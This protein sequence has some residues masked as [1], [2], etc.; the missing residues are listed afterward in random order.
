MPGPPI[1]QGEANLLSALVVRQ[2]LVPT[3]STQ[4]PTG[5][6]RARLSA[7]QNGCRRLLIPR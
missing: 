1:G 7:L 4:R 5:S 2:G 3:A 6:G